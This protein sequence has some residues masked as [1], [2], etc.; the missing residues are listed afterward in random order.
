MTSLAPDPALPQRE[1]LLDAPAVAPVLV[2]ALG[3][4]GACAVARVK[5]RVGESLR[6]RYRVTVDGRAYEVA[7]RAFASG[8]AERAYEAAL[9]RVVPAGALRPVAWAP[10]LETVFW[11]FPN[12]RRLGLA[13]LGGLAAALVAYAPE[14]SATFRRDGADGR[15]LAYLKVYAGDGA[16]RALAAHELLGGGGVRLPHPLGWSRTLRALLVEALPGRPLAA[17]G[18]NELERGYR[19]LGTAAARLHR[20]P[21]PDGRRFRR[22]DPDRL[23]HAAELIGIARPD[24]A[25]AAAAL[26]AELERRAAC[27][28]PAVCLHGDLH[29]KN[30][31]LDGGGLGLVDLDQVAAGPPAAE[32]GSVLAGLR[33]ARLAEGLP[34]VRE[35]RLAAGFLAGYAQAAP[36]PAAALLRWHTAAALLAER[37]LR[38][39]N[40]VRPAG[41]AR[42]PL[43]LADAR[44][45][46]DA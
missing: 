19:L 30:A 39:V 45:L 6:V 25:G 9:E 21:A 32:L 33:Y 18:G 46:L 26:A 31:I 35:R 34:E 4:V 42:L 20:L 8:R 15:A 44:R 36:L 37:A 27:G 41:L 24:D 28:G 1:L 22:F 11:T 2:R 5:Y 10:G 29:P 16:E 43:L 23:R 14:K 40:R 17:L 3:P 7:C 12:D 13:P 38:A